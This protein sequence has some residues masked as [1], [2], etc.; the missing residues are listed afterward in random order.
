MA[1]NRNAEQGKRGERDACQMLTDLIGLEI[2]RL[3]TEG[4]HDDIG[5]LSGLTGFTVQVATSVNHGLVLRHKVEECR[6]QQANAGTP[7]GVTL[8]CIRQTGGRPPLWRFVL[9]PE[10]FAEVYFALDHDGL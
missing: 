10:Q 9:T 5:D 6:L 4:R 1:R 2:K 8:L 3:K 7:F